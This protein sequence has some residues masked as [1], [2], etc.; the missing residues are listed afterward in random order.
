MKVDRVQ[1][2]FFVFSRRK[3][4]IKK[5]EN[6][7]KNKKVYCWTTSQPSCHFKSVLW[8]YTHTHTHG[9]T[10]SERVHAQ[11]SWLNDSLSQPLNL[12]VLEADW[13][14]SAALVNNAELQ[15]LEGGTH[16]AFSSAAIFG[17]ANARAGQLVAV[18]GW[19]TEEGQTAGLPLSDGKQGKSRGALSVTNGTNNAT[20]HRWTL[21]PIGDWKG[22]K[23]SRVVSTC[24]T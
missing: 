20:H 24:T 15:V 3:A 7:T 13:Q 17:P 4:V 14:A 21:S 22:E 2:C 12:L 9:R 10:H 5:R 6:I 8:K 11:S 1:C 19:R 23:G 16:A 18:L